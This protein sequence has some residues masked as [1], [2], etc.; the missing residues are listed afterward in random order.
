MLLQIPTLST[1]VDHDVTIVN[2]DG[3]GLHDEDGNNKLFY[4]QQHVSLW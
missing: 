1:H 3:I 2:F 4:I